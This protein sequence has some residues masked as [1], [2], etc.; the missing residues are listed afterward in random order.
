MPRL[1]E[2]PE[3]RV[4]PPVKPPVCQL[5]D[6]L[7]LLDHQLL[8]LHNLVIRQLAEFLGQPVERREPELLVPQDTVRLPWKIKECG[9]TEK[10]GDPQRTAVEPK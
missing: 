3:P 8:A 4:R 10:I 1:V 7:E 6:L 9:G 5:V 2:F